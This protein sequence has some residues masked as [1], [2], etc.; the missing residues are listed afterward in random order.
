MT[1]PSHRPGLHARAFSL[2]EVIL[3]LTI[4]AVLMSAALITF[5]G[6]KYTVQESARRGQMARDAQLVVDMMSR[7][8][9]SLGAGVPQGACLNGCS[10]VTETLTP[11]LRRATSDAFAFV[12]DAAYPNAE[13][14]GAALLTRIAGDADSASVAMTAEVTGPC[15][16][17][18]TGASNAYQ[19]T[20]STTTPLAGAFVNTDNCNQAQPNARTCPWEMNKWQASNAVNAHL[21][22][23]DAAGDFYQRRWDGT[24]AIVDN[25]YGITVQ[26]ETGGSSV[27]TRNN[28]YDPI[29]SGYISHLD[30]IFWSVE[31]AGGGTCDAGDTCTVK[32]R[33]CWG[34]I[35]TPSDA[36]FPSAGTAAFVSPSDPLNC[37]APNEGTGWETI[38]DGVTSFDIT[39]FG[40]N[41]VAIAAPVPVANLRSVRSLVITMEVQERVGQGPFLTHRVQ[42]RLFLPNR[43]VE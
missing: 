8:L 36:A 25:Y 40:A 10:A 6:G 7:D 21:T 30:R 19:C 31:D 20:T 35:E 12:G 41:G 27:L 1:H 16:P 32:R 39:Y 28:F 4:S 43:E 26:N 38:V 22:F 15:T 14:S 9:A 42:Q 3:A 2:V 23:V 18:A 34:R 33:Q 11:A 13:I 17:P 5:S 37:A 29:G 24:T